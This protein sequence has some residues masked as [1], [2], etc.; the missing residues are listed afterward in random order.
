MRTPDFRRLSRPA[1]VL[2]TV[3]G[4]FLGLLAFAVAAWLYRTG[5]RDAASIAADGSLLVALVCTA[6]LTLLDGPASMRRARVPIGRVLPQQWWP[7]DT[8]PMP[9]LA[10]C[11][12]GPLIVGAGAAVLLFR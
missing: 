11:V 7:R 1:P 9:L 12:G 5:A 8:D 10:A 2:A 4:A 3:C 6:A